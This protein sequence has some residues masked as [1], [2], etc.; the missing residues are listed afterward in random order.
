MDIWRNVRIHFFLLR[1]DTMLHIMNSSR[2][3]RLH[4]SS[5]GM[6]TSRV[7]SIDMTRGSEPWSQIFSST[8]ISVYLATTWRTGSSSSTSSHIKCIGLSSPSWATRALSLFDG[9][10]Q[11]DLKCPSSRY[12]WHL[13]F[14]MSN[15]FLL[16]GVSSSSSRPAHHHLDQRCAFSLGI[17]YPYFSYSWILIF[18]LLKEPTTAS[19]WALDAHPAS[20]HH[21]WFSSFDCTLWIARPNNRTWESWDQHTTHTAQLPTTTRRKGL[22]T[23]IYSNISLRP[24]IPLTNVATLE[25]NVHRL[26]LSHLQ[27]L[28]TFQYGL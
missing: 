19:S 18:F 10:Q 23:E 22:T 15:F 7:S 11:S 28:V 16:S 21:R 6:N 3:V 14:F 2:H 9:F 12:L 25:E 1:R 8:C 24:W 26:M 13:T 17:A 5:I 4:T 20:H 27:F